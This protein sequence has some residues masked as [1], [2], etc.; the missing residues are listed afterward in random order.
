MQNV[1]GAK[2]GESKRHHRELIW[3]YCATSS[4]FFIPSSNSNLVIA[5]A[6]VNPTKHFGSRKS[7]KQVSN[8]RQWVSILHCHLVESIIIHTHPQ[9]PIILVNKKDGCSIWWLVRF[10]VSF[11]EKFLKL[12]LKHFQL[13][14]IHLIWGLGERCH[15]RHHFDHMVNLSSWGQLIEQLFGHHV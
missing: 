5:R 2:C 8:P 10:D 13:F 9:R 7:I 14:M 15:S 1:A 12:N 3:L 11:C 6:Q 4:L